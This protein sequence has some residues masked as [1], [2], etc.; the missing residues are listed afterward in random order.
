M[1]II[2]PINEVESK[3]YEIII[4][5]NYRRKQKRENDDKLKKNIDE[6]CGKKNSN[7]K[8]KKINIEMLK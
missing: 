3:L 6:L 8:D 4:D 2:I 5:I 7:E 1:K